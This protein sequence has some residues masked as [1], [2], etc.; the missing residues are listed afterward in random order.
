MERV[1]LVLGLHAHLRNALHKCISYFTTETE[2][3]GREKLMKTVGGSWR[4]IQSAS[5]FAVPI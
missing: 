5:S 3:C 2:Q 4:I 1:T